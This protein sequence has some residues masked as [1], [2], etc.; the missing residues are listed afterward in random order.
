MT[1]SQFEGNANVATAENRDNFDFRDIAQDVRFSQVYVEA[2]EDTHDFA[3]DEIFRDDAPL[4][5]PK[6]INF[7]QPGSRIFG[8]DCR[9]PAIPGESGRRISSMRR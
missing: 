5:T 2:A 3:A 4:P 8:S 1:I 7:V 6:D 9:N